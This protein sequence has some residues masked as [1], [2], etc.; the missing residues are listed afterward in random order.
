MIKF[1]SKYW[2]VLVAIIAILIAFIVTIKEKNIN[3]NGIVTITPTPI[4]G[5]LNKP[6]IDTSTASVGVGPNPSGSPEIIKQ[7]EAELQQNKNDYP[8]VDKLPY[9]GS[10]FTIDH[11]LNP[12]Q[13]V[14]YI[15]T[16]VNKN[17]ITTAIG[18]WLKS[19]GFE[20]N[21]HTIKWVEN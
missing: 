5:A 18:E 9:K 20:A 8:L 11:Y 4:I 21:S 3:N 16:G 2:L 13:L 12:K 1:I 15:K 19:N 6:T 10:N 14:V 17:T 7:Q